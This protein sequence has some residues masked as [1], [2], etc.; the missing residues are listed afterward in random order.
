MTQ[1][2]QTTSDGCLWIF[3][4]MVITVV[5]FGF[6]KILTGVSDLFAIAIALVIAI[7]LTS[8]MLGRPSLRSLLRNVLVIF[9]L[10]IGIKTAG[11]FLIN[12]LK[13]FEFEHSTFTS[14]EIVT[15]DY[16]LERNDTIPVF[17][18][19][20][21]WK[22]NYGNSYT[23][24]LAV[25]ERDF[26]SLRNHINNYVPPAGGNFWGNLY[27]YMDKKDTPSLDLVI[28]TFKKINE[29][30]QLDQMEFAEMVVSCIQ[31]IPYSFVFQEKCLPA[32]YYE[33]EIKTILEKC[34]ECCIGNVAYGV[35]NPVS[36]IQNLKGDCDTRTV[37][38]Y[39]ILKYFN[40]DVAILNSDFYRHSIIG[41]HLPASGLNKIYNGK[42][43]ILWETT[44][45]YFKAG[46]LPATFN[47]VTY[48]NVV[49][50]SK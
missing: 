20:R 34:P 1:K 24:D 48:W 19:S 3:I 16:I 2:Q 41:I 26:T 40:Y 49:L 35:Q 32:S 25:R 44:A 39:S 42:K 14:E 30:K 31:D 27:R 45:K 8:K 7:I 22:D 29:E 9:V 23:G 37:L 47:D 50:T 38:I 36:F 12:L 6:I 10:V 13:T 11:N 18:S 46:D 15:N 33:D 4:T 43:Y 5:S 21:F 17:K 28:E